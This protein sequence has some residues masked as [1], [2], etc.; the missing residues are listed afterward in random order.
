[1]INTFDDNENQIFILCCRRL[2]IYIFTV[3][4]ISHMSQIA[5][6]QTSASNKIILGTEG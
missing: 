4:Q 5:I 3:E 6:K 1:M 2:I